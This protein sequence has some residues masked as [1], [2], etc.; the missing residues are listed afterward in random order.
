MKIK[1]PKILVKSELININNTLSTIAEVVLVLINKKEFKIVK[2]KPKYINNL[3][4]K[5]FTGPN[6]T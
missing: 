2:N 6:N 4:V 3:Y 1:S 5:L